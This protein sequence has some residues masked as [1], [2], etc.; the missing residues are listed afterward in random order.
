MST[1]HPCT[2][3]IL[4]LADALLDF[5]NRGHVDLAKRLSEKWDRPSDRLRDA[6]NKRAH[7]SQDTG[8][9][10]PPRFRVS[11]T[12][13]LR[14]QQWLRRH[15]L[16]ADAEAIGQR[17][18]ALLDA[19][20]QW[21]KEAAS[22]MELNRPACARIQG[23][24]PELQDWFGRQLCEA[25][26]GIIFEADPLEDCLR[27]LAHDVTKRIESTKREAVP[28]VPP[29]DEF[30]EVAELANSVLRGGERRLVELLLEE[31]R[32]PIGDVGIRANIR[33]ANRTKAHVNKKLLGI[34]WEIGQ[35]DNDWLLRRVS[36]QAE[37]RQ[38]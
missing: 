7:Y 8:P 13:L 15:G 1:W 5:G 28:P 31:G 29:L 25:F 33:D 23:H 10:Q 38:K 6:V 34:G 14:L 27:Q 20:V 35:H 37:P 22:Q 32:V 3:G 12:R 19:L 24:A 36:P 26:D 11:E 18:Q 9:K 4:P 21:E 17:L 16:E 30:R 2:D